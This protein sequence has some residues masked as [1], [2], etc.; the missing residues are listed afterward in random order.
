MTASK[1]ENSVGIVEKRFFTFGDARNGLPLEL[2]SHIGPVTV[3]YET[4]GTLNPRKDNAILICHALTGDSHVAGYYDENDRK[5]GW[6][7]YMVGPGKGIDTDRFFVICANV[8]G[9]CKGSTGPSSVNPATGTPYGSDFKAITIGDMV[10][11]QK[12]LL[13]HLGIE[14]LFSVIGGS[15][16]GMQVLQWCAAYPEKVGS[17]IALATTMRHSALSIAFNEVARRS[18]TGDP[19]WNGGDYYSGSPPNL[20]LSLARMVGHITYLSDEAMH[21][22]FGRRLQDRDDGDPDVDAVFKVESYLHYQGASFIER[23]DANSLLHI[24]RAADHFDVQQKYS[25]LG[26]HEKMAARASRYLVVSFSSDWLYPTYQSRAIVKTLKKIGCSVSFCEIASNGGHDSF[27]LPN[28]RLTGIL[29]GF[30][31]GVGSGA[32][33][34]RRECTIGV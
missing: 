13:D 25:L 11:A 34:G 26:P 9:G 29:N 18:I 4:C 31:A 30:L 24:T 14:K 5:P 7:E 15:L 28:D 21:L 12:E 22:K 23:F 10:N 27:L 19:N 20:G 8:L 3:A 17:A 1:L 2:G 32:A 6:W 16:G 33:P